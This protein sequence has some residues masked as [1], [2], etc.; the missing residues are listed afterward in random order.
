MFDIS[1]GAVLGIILIIFGVIAIVKGDISAI[2][3]Y[4]PHYQYVPEAEKRL[5]AKNLGIGVILM[6]VGCI[7]LSYLNDLTNTGSAF[8]IGIIIIVVGYAKFMLTIRKFNKK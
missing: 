3:K 7:S 2:Y 8:W 5:F 6:G 1:I 4:T